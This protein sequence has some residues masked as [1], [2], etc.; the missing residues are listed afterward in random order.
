MLERISSL[1]EFTKI[2]KDAAGFIYNNFLK[3]ETLRL[4]SEETKNNFAES[5]NKN[6]VDGLVGVAYEKYT[7]LYL[8]PRLKETS[9]KLY[10]FLERELFSLKEFEE[11]SN[12][13]CA[14]AVQFN[15]LDGMTSHRDYSYNLQ[16]LGTLVLDGEILFGSSLKKREDAY[17]LSNLVLAGEGDLIELK[18]PSKNNNERPFFSILS[19]GPSLILRIWMREKSNCPACSGVYNEQK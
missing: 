17:K 8:C 9:P 3:G 14:T 2:G 5:K 19:P 13:W 1:D 6:K 16:I 12:K 7:D 15:P 4:I 18:A 10:T 11:H